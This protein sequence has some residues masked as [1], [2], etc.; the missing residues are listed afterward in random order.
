MDGPGMIRGCLGRSCWGD[1][2]LG[3]Y[4]MAWS[5]V[6]MRFMGID[7]VGSQRGSGR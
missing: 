4:R 1:S 2:S 5:Y 7:H 6:G 3:R